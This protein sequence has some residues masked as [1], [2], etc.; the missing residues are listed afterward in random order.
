MWELTIHQ[1][2]TTWGELVPVMVVAKFDNFVDCMITT[3]KLTQGLQALDFASSY[4]MLCVN[5]S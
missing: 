1:L 4:L 2:S 5:V 3:T